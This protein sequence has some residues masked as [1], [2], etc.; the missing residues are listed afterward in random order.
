M[1]T[2]MLPS[3]VNSHFYH[4]PKTGGR[5]IVSAF[6]ELDSPNMNLSTEDMWGFVVDRITSRE[7]YD[8]MGSSLNIHGFDIRTY[9]SKFLTFGHNTYHRV[10][11]AAQEQG[12]S[13]EQM[14][15]CCS[16]TVVRDP[17]SRIFSYYKEYL[18]ELFRDNTTTSIHELCPKSDRE[19]YERKEWTFEDF[20]KALPNERKLEQ[21]YYFSETFDINEAI[22]NIEKLSSVVIC[23]KNKKGISSI[24]K[25]IGLDLKVEHGFSRSSSYKISKREM[26]FA[27]KELELEYDFYKVLYERYA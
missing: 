9:G 6:G 4:I 18:E 11:S 26:E 20:I 1:S 21:V 25:H 15:S 10:F 7:N 17:L 8:S 3:S 24:S 2:N 27:S 22:G 19:L 13:R 14:E 12:P 23:E 16:F 5:S